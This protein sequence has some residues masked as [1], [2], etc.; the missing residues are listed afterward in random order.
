M[1]MKGRQYRGY[2]YVDADAL[3]AQSSLD[4][5]INISLEYNGKSAKVPRMRRSRCFRKSPAQFHALR[6]RLIPKVRIAA[7]GSNHQA[8][9]FE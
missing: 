7:S 5:W 9:I 2:V 1:I 8:S 4:Y 6:R 3:R